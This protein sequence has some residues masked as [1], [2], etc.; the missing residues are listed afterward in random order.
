MKKTDR[1]FCIPAPALFLFHI[2]QDVS[3]FVD[4][5][6]VWSDVDS[7]RC[8]NEIFL[9]IPLRTLFNILLQI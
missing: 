8:N 7:I 2:Y 1:Y 6:L 5:F 4:L 9:N 3:I